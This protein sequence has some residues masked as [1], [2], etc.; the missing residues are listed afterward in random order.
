MKPNPNPNP[1]AP[2]SPTPWRNYA[3]LT[4]EKAAEYLRVK[5]HT[6]WNHREEIPFLKAGRHYLYEKKSWTG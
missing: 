5:L 3:Y 6:L 4:R 1:K 2:K